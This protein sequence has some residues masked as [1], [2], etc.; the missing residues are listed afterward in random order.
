MTAKNQLIQKIFREPTYTF[1][2]TLALM[3]YIG[4]MC[5]FFD[6]VIQINPLASA[7]L[8]A[9]GGLLCLIGICIKTK[10]VRA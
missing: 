4:G 5:A 1:F 2:Q 9:F 7:L 3:A 6:S 10:G 8:C